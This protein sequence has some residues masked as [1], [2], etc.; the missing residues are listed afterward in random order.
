M[1]RSFPSDIGYPELLMWSSFL[2]R[3]VQIHSVEVELAADSGHPLAS[4]IRMPIP[5][6]MG[7]SQLELPPF[8]TM[9]CWTPDHREW[10]YVPPVET[11]ELTSSS[12]LWI[13]DSLCD[14]NCNG[15]QTFNSSQSS[16]LTNLSTP[17]TIT[18]GSGNTQ[19]Y[20]VKDVVQVAGFS[21]Q[22]QVFGNYPSSSSKKSS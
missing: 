9:S 8:P 11:L 19:G 1:H 5:P 22:N 12:D 3:L 13:A 20:L 6:T 21:V 4:R 10:H 18:Y 17:F 2:C 7:Q 14:N 16:S 15:I